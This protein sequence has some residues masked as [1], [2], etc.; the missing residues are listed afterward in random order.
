M[1]VPAQDPPAPRLAAPA[2][3]GDDD[4]IPAQTDEQ[5]NLDALFDR[6]VRWRATRRLFGPPPRM[7]ATLGNLA[8]APTRPISQDGPDAPC[9]A[10]LAALHIAYC[11]Q[12]AALGKRVFELHYLHRV[13]PI[14]RAAAALGISRGHYYR[15]LAEFRARVALAAQNIL[16]ENIEVAQRLPHAV[17]GET[18]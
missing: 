5:S 12:P 9:S 10:E 17:K 13:T 4:E 18:P 16:A 6:W 3:T 1:T 15:V 2:P 8:G 14:K 7:G 11:S